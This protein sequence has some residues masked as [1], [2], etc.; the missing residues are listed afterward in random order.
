MDFQ[1]PVGVM[2]VG[3]MP[4]HWGLGLLSN[5]GGSGNNDP[6]V[7]TGKPKRH[8]ADYYFANDFGDSHFGAT[9]D[10]ILFATKPLSIVKTIEKEP[11]TTSNFIIA[12][13]YDKIS[14]APY[15][16]FDPTRRFRPYGQQGFISRGDP[17]DDV[18]EH[19][20]VAVY[21]DPD[22][23]QVRY[24][25][26]L[27]LGAYVVIRD[28]AQSFTA[29]NL[30]PPNTPDQCASLSD[31]SS[32]V[33]SDE[34]SFVW[35]ADLWYRVRYDWFY[36][37]FEGYHIGGHTTGGVPFPGNN[38]YH[39]A[40]INT[41]AFR[42]GYMDDDLDGILEL[43]YNSGDDNLA[44]TSVK[45][46]P[47]DP[48]YNV[49]LILFPEVVRER[50]ARVFGPPF[51]S[52]AYPDGARPFMTDGGAVDAK[53]VLPKVRY[54]PGFGGFEFVGQ[55]LFAWVDQWSDA[56]NVFVCPQAGVSAKNCTA[57]KYLGTEF[58]LAIKD[59]FADNHMDFSLETGYL[60]FGDVLKT[61]S[62]QSGRTVINA[63]PGA[64][65]LQVRLAYLF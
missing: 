19:V 47:T 32:C 7:P 44:D 29:P 23:D 22:W 59:H 2:R 57:S 33:T 37:E 35:I 24:T 50:A 61:G 5:G 40:N 34:G 28:Q 15:L 4:S 27:R 39:T 53:Y 54:R 13:A 26:E 36:S 41:G 25:D 46:R 20:F 3:R 64:F 31:P 8:V 55:V 11:D 60:K 56:P 16:Y 12:Y 65:S 62:D 17:D 38:L 51:I 49:G 21:N 63:P 45:Q 6:L 18:N 30:G 14:E 52:A 42:V 48:D 58:D 9:V 1:V 43:G 10:R